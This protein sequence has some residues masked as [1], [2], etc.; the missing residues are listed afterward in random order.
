MNIKTLEDLMN[1]EQIDYLVDKYKDMHG[2]WPVSVNFYCYKNGERYRDV[3][4]CCF[5]RHLAKLAEQPVDH[6]DEEFFKH[7]DG[8]C[9]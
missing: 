1:C 6:Y 4:K 8:G 3:F 5:Y 2:P 7:Y 9:E